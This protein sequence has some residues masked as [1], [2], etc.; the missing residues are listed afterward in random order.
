MDH[1][2]TKKVATLTAIPKKTLYATK[3]VSMR[4]P[5]YQYNVKYYRV[6][7]KDNKINGY[8]WHGALTSAKY[9]DNGKHSYYSYPKKNI[10]ASTTPISS[11]YEDELDYSINLSNYANNSNFNNVAKTPSKKEMKTVIDFFSNPKNTKYIPNENIKFQN[12]SKRN[13]RIVKNSLSYKDNKKIEIPMLQLGI[14]VAG[15]T[16]Y[17]NKMNF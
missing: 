2:H 17:S 1:N 4:F 13:I 9:I 6:K 16:N 5:K 12:L 15:Q 11:I 10:L 14:N 7:S 3:L 8:I